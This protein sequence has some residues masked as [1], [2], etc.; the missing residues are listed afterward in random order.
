MSLEIKKG[1]K[2]TIFP[3]R[4]SAFYED[5]IYKMLKQSRIIIG[6]ILHVSSTT[7][8]L[9]VTWWHHNDEDLK[10]KIINIRFSDIMGFEAV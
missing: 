6:V 3:V 2:I 10:G 4:D 9:E 5:P 1:V 7:I 8:V